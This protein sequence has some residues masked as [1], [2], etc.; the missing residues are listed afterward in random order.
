LINDAGNTFEAL[1]DKL[2][3][4]NKVAYPPNLPEAHSSR[5]VCS[6]R[7]DQPIVKTKLIPG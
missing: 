3:R 5:K 6:K 4:L 7:Q 1:E 2:L